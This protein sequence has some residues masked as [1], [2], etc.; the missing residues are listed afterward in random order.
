MKLKSLAVAAAAAFIFPCSFGA[1]LE[2]VGSFGD[3]LLPKKVGADTP[4]A[5]LIHGG[6]W[7]AMDKKDVVGIGRFLADDLGWA[8][9][10]IN[11][12]LAGKAN[13]WPA[14]GE[15]CVKAGEFMFSDEFAAKTGLK[16]KKIMVIGGSAGGHLALW[17]GLKLGEKCDKIVSISGIAD[18]EPDFKAH[19]ERFRTL[20]GER[21]VTREML[22]SMSVMKLIRPNGPK[23]LLTHATEDRVVP[24]ASAKNFLAA[25]RSA[26]NEIGLFEYPRYLQEGLTGHCIWIPGSKPHRLIPRLEREIAYFLTPTP[27]PEPKPVETKYEISAH[28][29]PG[30][31]HMAEWDMVAK[32]NPERKPLLGWFD[33]TDPEN[34]DWQVKWAVEHG[35][36]AYCCCWYWNQGVQRLD[37]WVQA[38]YRAQHHRFLKWYV[39]YA[40]HNQEGAHSIAD[41]IAVSRFWIDNYFKTP[42]YYRINGKPVV[43]YCTAWNLD[44][45]IIAEAAKKGEKLRPGEGLKRAMSITERMA[46]EAGLPGVHWIYMNWMYDEKQVKSHPHHIGWLRTAGFA[47]QMPYHFGIWPA[48]IAPEA[49]SP[50]DNDLRCDFSVMCAAAEKLAEDADLTKDIPIWP[51]LPTGYD[52]TPRRFQHAIRI[53]NRTPEKF[54]NCCERIRSLCDRKGIRRLIVAPTSEWQEGS[55]IDP[56]EEYGFAYYDVIRDTFCEKPSA[57]WPKNLKPGDVGRPKL[58]FPPMY[59]APKPG[60]SFNRSQE[61]WYRNPFGTAKVDWDERGYISF[62]TGGGIVGVCEGMNCW[63][64]NI[65]TR[66]VPFSTADYSAMRLRMRITP[67]RGEAAPKSSVSTMRLYWGTK[68]RP[69]VGPDR[70]V[71]YSQGLVKGE[72]T[73][74]GKWHEYTLSMKGNLLWEG[75]VDELWLQATELRS[76]VVDIDWIRFVDT[77]EYDHVVHPGKDD[78]SEFWNRRANWFMYCPSFA[79]TNVQGAVK[80]RFTVA[81]SNGLSHVFAADKPTAPLTPVWSKL[82]VADISVVCEGIDQKGKAIGKAGERKFWKAAGFESGKYPLPDRDLRQ[83]AKATYEYAFNKPATRYLL[84]TGK[85]DMRDPINSYA[86]KNGSA[87]INAMIGYAKI[88]PAK[89]DEALHVAELAAEYLISLSQPA[90]TPLEYLAPT[91]AGAG[92]SD[93]GTRNADRTMLIYPAYV[94]GAFVKLAKATGKRRYLDLATKMGE[95][96]LR[97]QGED[98]TW[99]LKVFLKD[100]KPCNPNRLLPIGNLIPTMETLYEATGRKEF[101]DSAD[102]AFAYVDRTRLQNWNW[103]GQFEDVAPTAPYQNLTKH[104]ACSTAIY[105]GKRFPGDPKRIAQMRELLRYAEDQFV[106][107]EKPCNGGKVRPIAS[108]QPS[109]SYGKWLTPCALEQYECYWPIDA[110]ARKLMITYL[111]LYRAEHKAVDLEKAQVLAASVLKAQRKDGSIPTWWMNWDGKL[112]HKSGGN[113]WMNCMLATASSLIELA[114]TLSSY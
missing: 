69:L 90:G 83:A 33:E 36:S 84:E 40:N 59:R 13:P 22:D 50:R 87:L 1:D 7:S 62:R 43:V 86:S 95:T 92:E 29:Y 26:G 102:R 52:D 41:Q 103:E 12:R 73:M 82:P 80:Y 78:G 3:V 9:F 74:D 81:V 53:V 96:F 49:C 44:R 2:N 55:L 25:Y 97:L 18:P 51:S 77:D 16:P 63:Q 37:H 67:N 23:I 24:I 58:E 42:E 30:T 91:Y 57:G 76:A 34:L 114:D 60:W 105:L 110:S 54:R 109:K 32:T 14:C 98:G 66:C 79:F 93:V 21:E 56:A 47:A 112:V 89:R 107:W 108:W 38:F 10:N 8:V 19:P 100:G 75:E 28:Y 35:I 70:V 4:V 17:T 65:R 71:D 111:A 11:Y 15:D 85:F 39:M 27:V 6:G 5:L 104:D 72:V 46:K 94:M 88:E 99:Y 48:H 68:S 64:H 61:G 31:E 45:D 106:C 20:F 101:R 113:D